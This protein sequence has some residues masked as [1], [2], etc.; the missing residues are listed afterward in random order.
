DHCADL[1]NLR[2]DNIFRTSPVRRYDRSPYRDFIA[3]FLTNVDR[4][5]TGMDAFMR[6]VLGMYYVNG[7]DIVVDKEAAPAVRA[8]N[9]AQERQLGLLPYLHAFGPLERLDWACDHAG[10]Y[11]WARYDLGEVPPADEWAEATGTR[12]YLTVTPDRWRLYEV[13]GVGDG[14]RTTVQAGPTVLG[15]CPAVPFYFKEST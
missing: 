12:Q 2:V 11:L 10:R 13:A 6:R 5:G 3:A 14:D 15:V 4:G 9:L 8:R 1:I 7:V